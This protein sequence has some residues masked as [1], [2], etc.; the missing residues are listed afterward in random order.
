LPIRKQANLLKNTSSLH[1]HVS[2]EEERLPNP[3]PFSVYLTSHKLAIFG[4]AGHQL[5]SAPKYEGVDFHHC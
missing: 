3:N 5:G 4:N 2:A 1:F